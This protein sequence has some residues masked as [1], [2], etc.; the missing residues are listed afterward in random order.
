M[1][2][3][4]RQSSGPGVKQNLF[5]DIAT[6]AEMFELAVRFRHIDGWLGDDEG[7]LLYRLARD[8]EGA[9]AIVEIGSWMGRSTAWLASGSMA[10][11]RERVHA[12]DVFDGGPEHKEREVIRREGT[13]YHRFAENLEGLGLFGHVEP[14]IADSHE[15]ARQWNKG[16]IRLLFIDGNHEYS[17]VKDDFGLWTMHM[18]AGGLVVFDD[19]AEKHPGVWKFIGELR[20]ITAQWQHVISVGK[21]S[22]FRRIA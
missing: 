19:V 22:T 20:S 7:Y 12:V 16:P 1:M 13:T 18:P 10:S 15:A 3:E 17:A 14:I 2:V 21:T 11:G 5:D 4:K 6:V 8:A 9:G